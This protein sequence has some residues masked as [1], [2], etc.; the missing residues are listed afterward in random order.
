MHRLTS[1][2]YRLKGKAIL[3]SLNPFTIAKNRL[4]YAPD[5]TNINN[6]KPVNKPKKNFKFDLFLPL[7]ITQPE[8]N[9]TKL[10]MNIH[11]TG[12]F[13]ME[14]SIPDV[15]EKTSSTARAQKIAHPR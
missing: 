5:L 10:K 6:T 8:E 3:F 12:K 7:E 13:R 4:R 15:T 14:S 9:A 1:I 11:V 2:G